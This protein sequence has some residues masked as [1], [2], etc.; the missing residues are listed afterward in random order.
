PATI[1]SAG[2]QIALFADTIIASFLSAGALSALY[3]ADR[4]NQLPIGVIGI[5][6]GTVVLPEMA[7]RIAAGD[8]RGARHAQNRAIEFTLLLSVP[9]IGAFLLIPD[10]IMRAL[11]MRGAFTAADAAAAGQ[12]LA[13]YALGLL[14]FVLIRSV[15]ATFLARGDTATPV[16]AALMAAAVNIAFKVVFFSFTPL[17]QVGLAL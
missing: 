15:V 5:A 9:C 7:S 8:E 13:A 1:G 4:L 3:Y 12:T 6:A 14:P 16:K 10:L 2:L 11:F 17:A